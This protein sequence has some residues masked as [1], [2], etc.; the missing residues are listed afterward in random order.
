MSV[1]T[2]IQSSE[3]ILSRRRLGWAG[4]AAIAGCCVACSLPMIAAVLLGGGAAAASVS[5]ATPTAGLASG[6]LAFV[7][8]LGAFALRAQSRKAPTSSSQEI[9]IACDPS[10]FTKEEREQ[11]VRDCQRLLI[12]LP[13]ERQELQDGYLFHYQGSEESFVSLARWAAEEHRCCP[14]AQFSVDMEPFTQEVPGKV[15]MSMMGGVGGGAMLREALRDL[16]SRGGVVAEFLRG[17][18][19]L[20]TG[21]CPS[22]CG[23]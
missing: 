17:D 4:L 12:E 3:S 5:F 14:W 1:A 7:L 8:V 11:H 20:T 13:L 2:T 6:G 9:P 23:C 22:R 21:G 19:K 16:E 15:R 18:R 10:V